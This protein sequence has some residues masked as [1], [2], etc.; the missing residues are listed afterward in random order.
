VR[1]RARATLLAGL[2]VLGAVACS[3]TGPL[4]GVTPTPVVQQQT[5]SAV[6]GSLNEVG[7]LPFYPRPD[8]AQQLQG[9][10]GPDEVADL[11]SN[12]FAEALR[13]LDVRVV[14]PSDMAMVFENKGRAMSRL[15]PQTAI[16]VTAA[17]YGL[18]AIV[19][20]QV[21]RWRARGG[22]AYGAVQP[23]SVGFEASLFDVKTGRRLWRGRFD[24]TQRTLTGNFLAASKYP[25]G[26][27]RWLSVME[28][29][30]WGA[31]NAA[32]AMVDGQWRAS[33]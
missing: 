6:E 25:G 13:G 30:R 20:G 15:D 21:S 10:L 33:N 26:G 31:R 27:T 7:V 9:D 29:A 2:G 19:T 14:S 11:V 23:A 17:E 1:L 12:Y 4:A 22:Q 28:L 3:Q 18:S 16:E 24:H 8:L 5:F 32:R